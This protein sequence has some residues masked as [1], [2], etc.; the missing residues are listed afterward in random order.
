MG[1]VWTWEILAIAVCL[2]VRE[3]TGAENV[4]RRTGDEDTETGTA[5]R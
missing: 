3:G 2:V 1:W 5:G 4:E